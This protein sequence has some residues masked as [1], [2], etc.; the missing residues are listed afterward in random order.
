MNKV[1]R[2]L[3]IEDNPGDARLIEEMLK[4]I[5]DTFE[6]ECAE[7][8]S[9]GIEQI[10]VGTFD[11]ILLDLGLP[12]SQGLGTLT[13]LNDA[14]P[15]VPVVV[16]TGLADESVG[17]QAVKA[18]AQDYLIKGQIDKNLLARS[19]HYAVT[20]KKMEEAQL[21]SELRYRRLFEAAKDGIIILD[22]ETG[23]IIDVNAFLIALLG[24]PREAF[25]D[26]AIWDLGFLRDIVPNRANFLELQQKGYVRYDNRP[27]KA[28]DGRSIDVE[29]VSNVYEVNRHD[30]VQCNIRDITKRKQMEDWQH[31][32]HKTLMLLTSVGVNEEVFRNV[33]AEVKKTISFDAVAIR[34]RE[35]DDFPYYVTAGFSEDF[36]RTER[37]LCVNDAAEEIERDGDGT[38]AL[39]CMC[40]NI[41]RGRTDPELPFFTKGGSFWTN[42]ITQLMASATEAERQ[43]IIRMQC[44]GEGY[45]SV[46]LIPLQAD[47][48]KVGLL[49]LNDHR[50]NQFTLEMIS[51][52]EGLAS[53]IA[54]AVTRRWTQEK[55]NEEKTFTENALNNLEDMFIVFDLE[56]RFLRWNKTMSAVTGYSDREIASMKPADFVR[57]DDMERL[58]KAIQLAVQEGNASIELVV[59]TKDVRLIPH[60]FRAALLRDSSGT[61]I[62]ISAVGRDITERKKKEEELG[63]LTR[64]LQARN[65][66]S[67]VM[68]EAEDEHWYLT[69]VCRIIV[70]D[71]GHT[72]VWIGFADDDQDKTVRP[73]AYAGFEE[74]YL[75]SANITWADKGR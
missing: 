34:L 47:G 48:E 69:E 72:M 26:K 70:E 52:F 74:G 56:G 10:K 61:P 6:L 27:L 22:A 55:L 30:I 11:A 23:M 19:I 64:I 73:V 14:K 8:L 36:L 1:C 49:Q 66:S 68:I 29:F 60:E 18:G 39:E 50:P 46:A 71:C 2:I 21:A 42:S 32:A 75:E 65:D 7:R 20:R 9:S 53:S 45:E 3:L 28:A 58:S 16:L 13:R 35:G 67:R 12:D 54:V 17:T 31:L 41:L 57:N 15:E 44:N 59:V 24:F 33:L 51:F 25:F 5:G 4:E 40:G 62:G 38:P 43:T 63:K 37:F